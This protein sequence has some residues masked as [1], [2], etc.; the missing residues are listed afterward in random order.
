[1]IVA[2]SVMAQDGGENV[3]ESKVRE[4]PLII[5]NTCTDISKV[6]AEYIEKVKK[7]FKVFYIHTSHG[8]QITSGMKAMKSELYNFNA[9][10][11]GGA[12]KYF[13]LHGD[14][15]HTGD[16]RWRDG[17]GEIE[18]AR[19]RLKGELKD[20]N[21]FIA[22]WC[23]GCSDNNPEGITAYCNAM[24]E[25]EKEFPNVLFVYMTGHL[26]SRGPGSVLDKSNTQIREF[27]KENNK[28]LFDF[29]AIE[30]YDPDGNEF[31]TK[32]ADDACYYDKD[33]QKANWAEEWIARHP[34][35][36]MALP[37]E[38]A[39]THP[40]NGALKGRAFWWMMARLAGWDGK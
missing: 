16:M 4:T 13:E 18:G 30:S 37:E 2:F 22:S 32:N 33:G 36:G 38:A 1:M 25:L 27:C 9:T 17:M 35:H 7:D 31:F 23:G 20:C 6:P 29:A 10:G 15:G 19:A 14:L 26:D 8:S 28:I 39:H 3:V 21:V 24:D 40:L 11:E 34:D 5:D 12:M